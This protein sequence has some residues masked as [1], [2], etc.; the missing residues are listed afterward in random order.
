MDKDRAPSSIAS[1]ELQQKEIVNAIAEFS[2]AQS[3]RLEAL[4]FLLNLREKLSIFIKKMND[5]F[6]NL[7][8]QLY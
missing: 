2:I 4:E 5:K 3:T 1:F 6:D 8:Y 7:V